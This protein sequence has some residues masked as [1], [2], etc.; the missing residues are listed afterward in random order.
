MGS[1]IIELSSVDKLAITI[2]KEKVRCTARAICFGHSL[3][4]IVTDRKGKP[5]F[6]CHVLDRLRSI[7][8]LFVDIIGCNS[9]NTN[10]MCL[11]IFTNA[12]KF[13]LY[14][15]DIGAVSANKHN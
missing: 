5:K 2:E 13:I 4:L 3:T 11:I 10:V 7:I 6:Q 14:M 8:G 9:D 12:S 15:F 1:A